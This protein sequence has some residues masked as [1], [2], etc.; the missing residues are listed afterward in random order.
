MQEDQPENGGA[1]VKSP[2]R[3]MSTNATDDTSEATSEEESRRYAEL[4]IGDEEFVVYD[5]ENHQAWVQSTVSLD[6]AELR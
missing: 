6:V 1:G 2:R 5:R 3:P 4:H